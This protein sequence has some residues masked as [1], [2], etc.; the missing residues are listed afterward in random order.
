MDW[1][2]MEEAIKNEMKW[3]EQLNKMKKKKRIKTRKQNHYK[4]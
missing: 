3:Y 4:K 1:N 2:L